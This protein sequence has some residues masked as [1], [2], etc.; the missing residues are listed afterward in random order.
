MPFLFFPWQWCFEKASLFEAQYI[1]YDKSQ[2]LHHQ[3]YKYINDII[4][5]NLMI[6][7]IPKGP[8][9]E[10]ESVLQTGNTVSAWAAQE[11]PPPIPRRTTRLIDLKTVSTDHSR[12]I[13]F[14]MS[15]LGIRTLRRSRDTALSTLDLDRTKTVSTDHSLVIAY[16]PKRPAREGLVMHHYIHLK[17]LTSFI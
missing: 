13:G 3:L 6:N 16:T 8:T 2:N 10:T 11:A 9:I 14:D 7:I 17:V 12:Q 15:T 1:I 4:S 5:T